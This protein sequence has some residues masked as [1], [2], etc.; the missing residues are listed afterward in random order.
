MEYFCYKNLFDPENNSK[1]INDEFL[2]KKTVTTLLNK[3]FQQIKK[4]M[5]KKWKSSLETMIYKC[6][7]RG[8]HLSIKNLR[9]SK[10]LDFGQM[11]TY[12]M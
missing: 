2:T 1:V 4:L 3:I 10:I 8:S 5:K 12:C 6:N 9:L 11:L 7:V